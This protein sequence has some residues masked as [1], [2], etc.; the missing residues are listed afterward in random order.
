M[1]ADFL[2]WLLVADPLLD[3]VADLVVGTVTLLLGSVLGMS[4]RHLYNSN[5]IKRHDSSLTPYNANRS[6]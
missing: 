2:I 4:L 5:L 6:K 1:A 3:L